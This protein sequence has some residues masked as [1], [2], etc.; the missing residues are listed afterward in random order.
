MHG[1]LP[2]SPHACFAPP[3]GAR[4]RVVVPK[5]IE[6]VSANSLGSLQQPEKTLVHLTHSVSKRCSDYESKPSA[7]TSSRVKGMCIRVATIPFDRRPGPSNSCNTKR[8]ASFRVQ[9]LAVML[10]GKSTSMPCAS[11]GKI[12]N[13]YSVSPPDQRFFWMMPDFLAGS[14]A[15]D[16]DSYDFTLFKRRPEDNFVAVYEID[17]C[18]STFRLS[19]YASPI[20]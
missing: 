1:Q 3:P 13:G 19:T 17:N 15:K 9:W 14:E 12:C 16:V 4:Q 5:P 8:L 18:V 20:N 6:N 10:S 2:L 7:M 11:N